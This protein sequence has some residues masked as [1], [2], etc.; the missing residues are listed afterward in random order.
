MSDVSYRRLA[1]SVAIGALLGSAVFAR[2]EDA[3]PLPKPSLNPLGALAKTSFTGFIEK[4]LFDPTR[5]LPPPVPVVQE[6]VQVAVAP[7][8]PPENPPNLHL[9]GIIQGEHNIA[10]VHRGEDT[11]TE[12]FSD[13]DTIDG[14]E[15]VV[16]PGLGVQLRKGDRVVDLKLFGVDAPTGGAPATNLAQNLDDLEPG[17]QLAAQAA[18][19]RALQAR[20]ERLHD[21]TY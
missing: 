19:V 7:P 11:K 9:L 17:A 5:R 6:V 20:N 16:P 8:P 21:R 12:M 3:A 1:V 14:W 10:V 2:A 4:P 15:V 18:Q 13:G